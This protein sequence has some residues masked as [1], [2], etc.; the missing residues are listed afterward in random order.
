MVEIKSQDLFVNIVGVFKKLK[1]WIEVKV[2]SGL[3]FRIKIDTLQFVPNLTTK[4]CY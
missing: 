2:I 1:S 4:G 3:L